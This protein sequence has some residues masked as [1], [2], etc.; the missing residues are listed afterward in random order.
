MGGSWC[1]SLME[2][3][4]TWEHVASR[5]E[6]MWVSGDVRME[7]TRRYIYGCCC[8]ERRRE[9]V[10]STVSSKDYLYRNTTVSTPAQI[11]TFCSHIIQ[12]V[13][14]SMTLAMSRVAKFPRPAG[15]TSRTHFLLPTRCKRKIRLLLRHPNWR[16]LWFAYLV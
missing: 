2:Y 3:Q 12:S 9:T 15:D 14:L 13:A 8:P 6:K 4:G 1:Y 16:L 7:V 10:A 5:S 11:E